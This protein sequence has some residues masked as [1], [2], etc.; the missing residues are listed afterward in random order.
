MKN[1]QGCFCAPSQCLIQCDLT[2]GSS[3]KM[4][5]SLIFKLPSPIRLVNI[6]SVN[7]FHEFKRDCRLKMYRYVIHTFYISL[8]QPLAEK[9]TGNTL[10]NASYPMQYCRILASFPP[11]IVI[12][13]TD[14]PPLPP[15]IQYNL[16]IL[17]GKT[18]FL[19]E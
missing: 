15:G 2:P 18:I 11:S 13:I 7:N 6:Y 5:L 14:T 3:S 8:M 10:K 1:R 12:L 4:F 17:S 16:F 19:I 9:V